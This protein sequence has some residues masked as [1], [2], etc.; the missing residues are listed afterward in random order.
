MTDR[1]EF[2]DPELEEL[3]KRLF[4][5]LSVQS[6][7]DVSERL[8]TIKK[9]IDL[10]VVQSGENSARGSHRWVSRELKSV[11]AVWKTS[12]FGIGVLTMA[13]VLIIFGINFIPAGIND[14]VDTTKFQT[15]V[16]KPGQR[17]RFQL[18]DGSSVLLAAGSTLRY[19]PDFGKS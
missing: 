16:T 8:Q 19:G 2:N 12:G 3:D 13:V 1:F 11:G 9:N 7:S 15:Y 4:E 5:K 6:V 17:A 18:A 10:S 14:A